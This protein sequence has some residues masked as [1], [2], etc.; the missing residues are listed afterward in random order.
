[1]VIVCTHPYFN[2]ETIEADRELEAYYERDV[3]VP[4]DEEGMY[5]YAVMIYPKLHW[6][7]A[8]DLVIND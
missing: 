8:S 3:M 6:K 2:Q 5:A 4:M 1:M 7:P